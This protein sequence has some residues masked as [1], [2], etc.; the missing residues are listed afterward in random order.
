MI[1]QALLS[2]VFAILKS[3]INFIP[4]GF[5]VPGWFTSFIAMVQKLLFF[6]PQ[7]VFIVILAYGIFKSGAL[8]TWAIIEWVY[9][10]IP[11]VD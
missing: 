1:I 2:P 6:F 3:L 8:I 5:D 10:K 7:D 11:G 9:K 4:M